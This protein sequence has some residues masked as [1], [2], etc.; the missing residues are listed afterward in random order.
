M[1]HYRTIGLLGIILLISAAWISS[2]AE[3]SNYIVYVQGGESSILDGEDGMYE[4]T[5]HDIIPFCSIIDG[6]EYFL[7]ETKNLANES[8][9]INALLIGTG[10]D[11]ELRT[12]AQISGLSIDEER[13]VMTLQVH[14]S[15]FSNGELLKPYSIKQG[16][17]ETLIGQEI[18]H[19]G[20]YLELQIPVAENY[21]APPVQCCYEGP[22]GRCYMVC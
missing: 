11:L 17:L 21:W 10:P 1:N 3:S 7:I 2:A 6:D 9:P 15:K 13:Q 22:Q 19:T 16:E 18:S 12:G 8:Y 20:L 14:P 4:I 5:I